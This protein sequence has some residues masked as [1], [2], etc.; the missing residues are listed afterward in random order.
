ML[1]HC[2]EGI[3]K[4]DGRMNKPPVCKSIPHSGITKYITGNDIRAGYNGK[5]QDHPPVNHLIIE[6][7]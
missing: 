5:K 4:I 3:Y 1:R 2:E 7:V 6:N